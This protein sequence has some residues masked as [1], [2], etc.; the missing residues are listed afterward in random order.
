MTAEK[1][2]TYCEYGLFEHLLIVFHL[3]IHVPVH[4]LCSVLGCILPRQ[5]L[6]HSQ[7]PPTFSVLVHV[8]P[9]CPSVSFPQHRFGLPSD[10]IPLSAIQCFLGS[11]YCHL[12]EQCAWP[13]PHFAFVMYSAMSVSLVLCLKM[14]FWSLSCG[15]TISICLPIA[16]WVDTCF[17]TWLSM[18]SLAGIF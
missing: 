7:S 12:F 11:I 9:W 1:F 14:V 17:L 13:I 10:L 18:C 6:V 2:C 16:N 4:V 5:E 15:L 8:I 3:L